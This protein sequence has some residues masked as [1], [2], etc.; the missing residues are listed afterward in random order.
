[1]KGLAFAKLS[2]LSRCPLSVDRCPLFELWKIEKT[3][4]Q[5]LGNVVS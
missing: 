5:R 1:M 2:H 3:T 4:Y